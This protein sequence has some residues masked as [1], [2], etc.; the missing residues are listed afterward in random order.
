MSG[1]SHVSERTNIYHNRVG[2]DFSI[3]PEFECGDYIHF[4]IKCLN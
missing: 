1:E 2:E 4:D 3:N